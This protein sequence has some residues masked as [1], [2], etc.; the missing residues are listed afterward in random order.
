[1]PETDLNFW[2]QS[3]QRGEELLQLGRSWVLNSVGQ[4]E[5]VTEGAGYSPEAEGKK[6]QTWTGEHMA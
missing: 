1:M 4:E 6:N 5:H 2:T 3:D